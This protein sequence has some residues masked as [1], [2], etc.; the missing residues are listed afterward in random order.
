MTVVGRRSPGCTAEL[1]NVV[2]PGLVCGVVRFP[3]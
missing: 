3:T 1:I 2:D